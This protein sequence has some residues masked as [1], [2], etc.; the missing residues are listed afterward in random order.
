MLCEAC[1]VAHAR[2]T[3]LFGAH[4]VR[5]LS[6]DPADADADADAAAAEQASAGEPAADVA[7]A[8]RVS[9]IH[10]DALATVGEVQRDLQACPPAAARRPA[11]SDGQAQKRNIWCDLPCRPCA[12]PAC[13]RSLRRPDTVVSLLPC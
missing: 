11:H 1:G 8:T 4:T 10:C 5:P 12:P 13:P 3:R 2:M 9:D 6:P 7:A